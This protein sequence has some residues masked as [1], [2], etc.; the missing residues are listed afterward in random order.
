ML[1]NSKQSL[2]TSHSSSI[3]MMCWSNFQSLKSST[4]VTLVLVIPSV[5]IT[6][7]T[8]GPPITICMSIQA[9]KTAL[10][11]RMQVSKVREL[12]WMGQY[13]QRACL[14]QCHALKGPI[15]LSAVRK[16]KSLS[17]RTPTSDIMQRVCAWI[18]TIGA[19]AQR[20][21]GSVYTPARCT[22]RK[23]SASSAILPA[24]TR[25]ERVGN[26]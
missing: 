21:P 17:V 5:A 9:L 3:S 20:R 2:Q 14:W 23:A 18:A 19:V 22:T 1:W 4:T 10:I 26:R 11:D 13:P 25:A 24:I 16:R 8:Q 6:S 12:A 7:V 15:K